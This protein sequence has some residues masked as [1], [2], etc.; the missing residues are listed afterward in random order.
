MDIKRVGRKT[1]SE[2][3]CIY[4]NKKYITE[5]KNSKIEITSKK[6]YE[7]FVEYVDVIG[8][9]VCLFDN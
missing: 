6:H 3:Y 8:K 7:G 9:E 2:T 1:M 5:I 4:K